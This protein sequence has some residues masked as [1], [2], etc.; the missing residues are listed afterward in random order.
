VCIREFG[1]SHREECRLRV[2]KNSVLRRIFVPKKGEI[3][4]EWRILQKEELYELYYSP[5]IV[6]R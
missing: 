5:T 2:F 3:A 1:C 6:F 4:G